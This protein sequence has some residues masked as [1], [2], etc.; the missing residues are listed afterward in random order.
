MS[1][2]MK[3]AFNS[4]RVARD[5]Q[6]GWSIYSIPDAP[7]SDDG[8]GEYLAAYL[9]GDTDMS[10]PAA[11]YRLVDGSYTLWWKRDG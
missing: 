11:V 1:W 10:R 2:W 6:A 9:D 4:C 7:R 3:E 5:E 8:W